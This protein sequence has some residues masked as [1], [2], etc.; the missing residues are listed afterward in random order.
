M[1]FAPLGGEFTTLEEMKDR[2]RELG[3]SVDGLS[4]VT[5][6]PKATLQKIFGGQ[7]KSPRRET[8]E[9]L[10][11]VLEKKSVSY[12]TP[13]Y[14]GSIVAEGTPV[15]AWNGTVHYL[16]N[17]YGNKKQGDYTIDD[18]LALPDDK[19][20]ELIDGVIYEM[21]SPSTNHQVIAAFLL[22]RLMICAE[23]HPS[24]CY[25]YIA[26]LDVQL[27]KDQ[28]TMVQPDI[29]ICCDPKQNTGK[30]LFGA[31]DFAAE[32]L[33]PSTRKK[34][35]FIKLNKYK[36]AGVREYWMIDPLK[37]KVIV[38]LFYKDDDIMIY[39]FD[40]E[41]PVSISDELCKVCFAPIKERLV[42]IENDE[43]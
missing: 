40:D 37:Q 17:P 1:F 8:I 4:K 10:T 38:Y 23:E 29:I 7:T 42:V 16:D 18:Y 13:E 24:P 33:S 5:G 25:P 27:D 28:K 19:R 20:Y 6:I 35:M 3:Y 12:H 22:H 21:A 14:R 39:S 15:K 31:P 41:I 9:K 43:S 11:A 34:D 32:V 36:N 2:K 26:P 30:R